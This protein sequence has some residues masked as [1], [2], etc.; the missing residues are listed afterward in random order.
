MEILDQ[1]AIY[2]SIREVILTAKRNVTHIS[3]RKT[4]K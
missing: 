2:Q 1:N 4:Q 3:L